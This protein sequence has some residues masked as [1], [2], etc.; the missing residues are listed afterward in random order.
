MARFSAA[1]TRSHGLALLMDIDKKPLLDLQ[2]NPIFSRNLQPKGLPWREDS[3]FTDAAGSPL[4]DARGQVLTGATVKDKA[5]H[6]ELLVLSQPSSR[7]MGPDDDLSGSESES[8]TSVQSAR[9]QHGLA[10]PPTVAAS[11]RQV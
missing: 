1:V 10:P 6:N 5:K 11:Q 3:I 4:C 9:A 2:G 7:F 8:A